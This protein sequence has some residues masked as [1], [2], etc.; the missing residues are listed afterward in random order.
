[1]DESKTLNLKTKTRKPLEEN[2]GEH[3]CHT[4]FGSNFMDMTPKTQK[5]KIVKLKFVK[6]KNICAS[7]NTIKKA[8]DNL[9]NDRKYF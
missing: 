5:K 1:M 2:I 8:K 7:K 4:G 6:I 3:I 9:M